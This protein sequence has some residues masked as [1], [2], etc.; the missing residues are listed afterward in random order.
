[1][2]LKKELNERNQSR[3]LASIVTLEK[4][5]FDNSDSKVS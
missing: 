1:M 4:K 5:V 2:K 3:L